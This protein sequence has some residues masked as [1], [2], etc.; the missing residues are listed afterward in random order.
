MTHHY[1]SQLRQV[2]VNILSLVFVLTELRTDL[3]STF[4]HLME[5]VGRQA[6]HG[7]VVNNESDFEV[8][9]LPVFH[10][11]R[12]GPDHTEVNQEDEGHRDGGVDQ[13][14]WVSPLVWKI[15]ELYVGDF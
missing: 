14:P 12:S 4:T 13:Q 9:G 11:T 7:E 10:Q 2:K 5:H 8:N 1:Y 6:D 15:M 3:V